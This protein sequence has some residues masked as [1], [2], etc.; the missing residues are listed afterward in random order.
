MCDDVYVCARI[1]KHMYT[2]V[3]RLRSL[4]QEYSNRES[5]SEQLPELGSE[6]IA[7]PVYARNTRT[8]PGSNRR[9]RS[10]HEGKR[11]SSSRLLR[12]KSRKKQK[13]SKLTKVTNSQEKRVLRDLVVGRAMDYFFKAAEI[14]KITDFAHAT[15][16]RLS[17]SSNVPEQ[18]TFEEWVRLQNC[19]GGLP[20]NAT[21]TEEWRNQHQRGLSASR[22]PMVVEISSHIKNIYQREYLIKRLVGQ[23]S[24]KDLSRNQYVQT[25]LELESKIVDILKCILKVEIL[26]PIGL[27]VHPSNSKYM[28]TPA[29]S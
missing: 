19:P 14:S 21:G 24:W 4:I 18:N 25:G 28:A 3:L 2:Y 12:V 16:T 23:Y 1:C 26:Y 17:M 27:Q 15:Y 10:A 9:T 11:S 20:S 13:V 6:H 5:T 29:C 7:N 22:I 8:G